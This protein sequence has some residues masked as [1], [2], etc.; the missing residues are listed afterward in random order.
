MGRAKVVPRLWDL[1]QCTAMR[2]T[3]YSFDTLGEDEALAI[4]EH[5]GR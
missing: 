2:E 3:D 4:G 1:P 5:H